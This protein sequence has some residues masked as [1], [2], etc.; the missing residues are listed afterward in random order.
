MQGNKFEDN[1]NKQLEELALRPTEGVWNRVEVTL[2]K[3]RKRRRL[4]FVLPLFLAIILGSYWWIRQPGR[5]MVTITDKSAIN[6]TRTLPKDSMK[7][8]GEP[9]KAKQDQ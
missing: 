3:D 7:L 2:R 1:V 9:A 5:Q 6:Q 8:S 4:F